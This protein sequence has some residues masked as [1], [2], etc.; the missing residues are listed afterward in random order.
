LAALWLGL[1]ISS[2][3]WQLLL[4]ALDI[5]MR[6][7][8]LSRLYWAAT[9]FQN[10]LPSS[11]GGDIVR[12]T[13]MRKSQRLAA[14]AASMFVERFT[15][16][17][18]LVCLALVALALRPEYFYLVDK[19]AI[20]W[21]IL[22]FIVLSLAIFMYFGEHVASYLIARMPK[23]NGLVCRSLAKFDRLMSSIGI[24]RKKKKAIIFTF[25]LSLFFYTTLVVFQYLTFISLGI[26]IPLKEVIFFAPIIPLISLLPVSLNGIGIAEGAFVILYT[27]LGVSPEEALAAALVRRLLLLVFSLYGGLYVLQGKVTPKVDSAYRE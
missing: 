25:M 3:K 23:N 27:Q 15:G 17:V 7:G 20:V 24:Y 6:L 9:F 5:Q 14:V 11:V 8:D 13:V 18:T 4:N 19:D 22:S 2:K 10:F 26:D 16:F 1:M 21:T 12:L